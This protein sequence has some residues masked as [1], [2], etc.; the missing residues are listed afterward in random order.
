[1]QLTWSGGKIETRL[2]KVMYEECL[3]RCV[4][5]IKAEEA[6]PEFCDFVSHVYNHDPQIF[7]TFT[8]LYRQDINVLV[9][10]TIGTDYPDSLTSR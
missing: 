4:N 9:S 8:Q 6:C 10:A 1:M 7:T 3:A 5:V 2:L